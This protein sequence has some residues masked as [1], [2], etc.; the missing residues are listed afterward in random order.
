MI[1]T[2]RG[3]QPCVARPLAWGNK[4][5]IYNPSY[6]CSGLIE[7]SPELSFMTLTVTTA[8]EKTSLF[9]FTYNDLRE[10]NAGITVQIGP[11]RTL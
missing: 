4:S 7:T 10:R 2:D 9:S 11:A 1:G 6:S 3:K 5:V 8:G